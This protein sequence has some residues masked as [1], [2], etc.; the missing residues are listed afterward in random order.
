IQQGVQGYLTEIEAWENL[1]DY[2]CQLIQNPEKHNQMRLAARE[3]VINNFSMKR[4]VA[5]LERVYLEVIG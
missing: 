1:S 3:R 4:M 2:C 5:E